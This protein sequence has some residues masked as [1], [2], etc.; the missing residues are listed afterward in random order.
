MSGL[1]ETLNDTTVLHDKVWI[2]FASPTVLAIKTPDLVIA[3]NKYEHVWKL[4][5]VVS[6]R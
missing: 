6:R 3:L 5:H 1:D 2:V 4:P